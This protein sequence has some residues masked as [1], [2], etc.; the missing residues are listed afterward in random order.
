MMTDPHAA[1]AREPAALETSMPADQGLPDAI[2]DRLLELHRRILEARALTLAGA[3]VPLELLAYHVKGSAVGE[4][5]HAGF[6]NVL[7][8]IRQTTI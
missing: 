2:G 8:T 3:T 4:A 1:W 7:T 5:G 6:K